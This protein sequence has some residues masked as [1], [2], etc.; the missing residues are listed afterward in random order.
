MTKKDDIIGGPM[1][2]NGSTPETVDIQQV[3]AIVGMKEVEIQ[4]LRG[5]LQQA[6]QALDTLRAAHPVPVE[7][8]Q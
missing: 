5:K 1:T 3:L 2:H 7:G 4:L 8:S 6:L